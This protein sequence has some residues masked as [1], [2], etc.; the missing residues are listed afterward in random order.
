MSNVESIEEFYKRKFD[1]MPD[2]IR[3]EIGHFN[4]FKLDPFVGD[5]AQPVP[6]KRRDFYKIMLVI[7]NSKVHYADKVVEVQ[8]Q[9]LSFS[10]PQIPYKWEHLDNIRSGVFCIFNQHFFHQYGNLNQYTVFQPGGTHLF[11]LT[12]E[13]VNQV[14][15]LFQRMFEEINSDYIHKYDVLRTL[16]FELLHFA[17]KM[18]PSATFDKQPINASQ[19]ISTLFLELLERQFPIDDNH[20]TV[21]LRSAS[22]FAKQLNVHVNHLNRALKDTTEKTTSQIIAER[23]LQE[24]KILLKHSAWTVSEIAYALGFTEVTHFKNFF[25]KHVQLSPLKFRNARSDGPVRLV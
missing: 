22:D 14:N 6:Y 8:K 3:N 25:K 21:N 19:R 13:Q 24:A 20:Q 2:N 9:A 1:W 5:K 11:E 16:V 23:I 4:V 18:E 7:G 17:M 15:S 10:N 12:D